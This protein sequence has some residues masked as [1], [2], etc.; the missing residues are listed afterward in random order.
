MI[1]KNIIQTCGFGIFLMLFS[2]QNL[3]VSTS[4]PTYLRWVGDI[5][6]DPKQDDANFSICHDENQVVQYF[7]T[8]QGIQY[9]NEKQALKKIIRQKYQPISKDGESGW[10]RIRFVVNCKGEAGRFRVLEADENYQ[11]KK[12][13]DKITNQLLEITK[14]LDGWQTVFYSNRGDKLDGVPQDYYMY[15]IFKLKNGQLTE[16]L[17]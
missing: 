3:P 14:S 4:E 12:F 5:L 6:Q 9:E 1:H 13:D 8:S 15:L 10:I 11:P 16:I 7:N 2:C 17:P